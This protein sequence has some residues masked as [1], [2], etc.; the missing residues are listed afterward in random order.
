LAIVLASLIVALVADNA[1]GKAQEWR[2]ATDLIVARALALRTRADNAIP[3]DSLRGIGLT[4][5][6]P[7]KSALHECA[8]MSVAPASVRPVAPAPGGAVLAGGSD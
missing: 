5:G 8:A 1:N 6:I 3:Q 4:A 2:R 7:P